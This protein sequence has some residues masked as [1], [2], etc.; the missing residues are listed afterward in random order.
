[1]PLLGSCIGAHNENYIQSFT[2]FATWDLSALPLTD[3]TIQYS[4]DQFDRAALVIGYAAKQVRM[5][6]GPSGS[7]TLYANAQSFLNSVG[8][9]GK[10][11]EWKDI[12][13]ENI[14]GVR[15]EPVITRGTSDSLAIGHMFV[16]DGCKYDL[17]EYEDVWRF[18]EDTTFY[19]PDRYGVILREKVYGTYKQD[20]AYQC[21]FGWNL[22]FY[23]SGS[24]A[25]DT[26]YVI[27]EIQG[28]N[29]N[30]R[31]FKLEK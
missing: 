1:M 11:V 3:N 4:S 8:V 7:G 14:V 21:N 15:K 2:R 28:F 19:D 31:Y 20:Y 17:V 9:K 10:F 22:S 24:D 18:L 29:T 16:I 13:L 6:F 27:S 23:P 12:N 30:R 26:Y 5:A 25:D